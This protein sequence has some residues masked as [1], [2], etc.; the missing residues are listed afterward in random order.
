MGWN[1][2]DGDIESTM[3]MGRN[4]LL[5]WVGKSIPNCT[6]KTLPLHKAILWKLSLLIHTHTLG[7][8]VIARFFVSR[9]HIILHLGEVFSH[10]SQYMRYS[11][12]LHINKA[13]G[14][15]HVI[16]SSKHPLFKQRLFNRWREKKWSVVLVLSLLFAFCWPF[17]SVIVLF[18]MFFETVESYSL[19]CS[20]GNK[21]S[22]C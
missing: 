14:G 11:E 6:W 2:N 13:E 17:V 16:I 21:W 3:H 20:R 9:M 12:S 7:T 22:L 1:E 19:I 10:T 8:Q 18:S 15:T 4:K 5:Y